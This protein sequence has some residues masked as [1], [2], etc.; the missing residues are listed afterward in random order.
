MNSRVFTGDSLRVYLHERID[1]L[2]EAADED[3]AALKDWIE[4]QLAVFGV[5]E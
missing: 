4:P 3:R 2:P 5:V 1:N